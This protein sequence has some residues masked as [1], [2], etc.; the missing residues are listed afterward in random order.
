MK[1]LLLQPP[2]L[3]S[4]FTRNGSL[5]PP[6]GLLQIA[7]NINNHSVEVLDADGIGWSDEETQQYI[8]NNSPQ[9]FGLGSTAYT[10][11]IVKKWA[12]YAKSLGSIVVV[13]GPQATVN[14]HEV[15]GLTQ[16]ID[17]VFR[18]EA[19][20]L[21][22]TFLDELDNNANSSLACL[23]WRD[24]ER[25]FIGKEISVVGNLDEIKLSKYENMPINKYWCPDSTSSP[26]V[27][28][29]TTR[30]CPHK[31]TF[32]SSPTVSG[33][34]VRRFGVENVLSVI[35]HVYSQHNVRQ[36]SFVDDVLTINRKHILSLCESIYKSFP[37]IHFFGNARADQIDNEISEALKKA[38]CHQLYLGFESGSQSI[39]NSISKGA[40]IEQLLRGANILKDVGIDRSIGFIIG[41]PGES[42]ESVSESIKLAK[43]INPERLQF[44]KFTP[45]PG[46][47]L[48]NQERPVNHGGF[49]GK[50]G[51]KLDLWI[52]R[53]YEECGYGTLA[54]A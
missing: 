38:G 20:L 24:N 33:R 26:M 22:E 54:N 31:C 53:A 12:D 17:F 11:N 28:I 16:S 34:K 8:K 48:A 19:E 7:A 41:L 47:P 23:C 52:E 35:D 25:H 29:S 18:G 49:H 10:L 21:F 39:L 6:L 27:T 46:S 44:T 36:I 14:P 40:S 9:V 15:L 3:C 45:L 2:G 4:E 5:Y 51:D 37:D 32:C 30:G 43:K 50:I 1:V 13:G 42:E